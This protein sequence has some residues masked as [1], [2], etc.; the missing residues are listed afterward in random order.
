[1]RASF[2]SGPHGCNTIAKDKE[3]RSCGF[4]HELKFWEQA[5]IAA[6]SKLPYL[7]ARGSFLHKSHAGF[8]QPA[9]TFV[10]PNPESFYCFGSL[11]CPCIGARVGHLEMMRRRFQEKINDSTN[12]LAAKPSVTI[13]GG[14]SAGWQAPRPRMGSVND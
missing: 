6:K 13:T 4:S 9:A 2:Q 5:V 3:E 11:F 10:S 8:Q 1:M 14:A 7:L 12:L